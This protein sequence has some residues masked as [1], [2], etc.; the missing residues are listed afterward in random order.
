MRLQPVNY[1]EY[2]DRIRP[3]IVECLKHQHE[4][5]VPEDVFADLRS[6]NAV[7]F[8]CED[9]FVVVK[10]TWAGNGDK[11]LL[12]WM[13]YSFVKRRPDQESILQEY[14]PDLEQIART[15]DSWF[16][17]FA[18]ARKGYERALPEGWEHLCTTWRRRIPD[19]N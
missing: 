15:T 5:M 10:S 11:Q 3:G 19:G 8:L 2:W 6:G 14:T 1:R 16:M 13:A 12:I 18:S 17:T 9:C 7:L 4:G